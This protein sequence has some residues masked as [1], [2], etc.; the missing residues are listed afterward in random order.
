M[1][2]PNRLILAILAPFFGLSTLALSQEIGQ[3]EESISVSLIATKEIAIEADLLLTSLN[4]T[5]E[6]I[7]VLERRE[8]S[9]IARESGLT[10]A[11]L[12]SLQ[13]AQLLLILERIHPDATSL[14][15]TRAVDRDNGRILWSDF[16]PSDGDLEKWVEHIGNKI[17]ATFLPKNRSDR[18]RVS[19]R[20]LISETPTGSSKFDLQEMTLTALTIEALS[21]WEK[22]DVIER[23]DLGQVEFERFLTKTDFGLEKQADFTISGSFE[24]SGE[25]ATARLRISDNQQARSK[26][27]HIS[28][29]HGGLAE[30]AKQIG[31]AIAAETL[32]DDAEAKLV[33]RR[34]VERFGPWEANQF[35]DE[36][37]R[38][39]RLGL[40][41]LAARQAAAVN[42]IDFS[43]D[44]R[45]DALQFYAE[46]FRLFPSMPGMNPEHAL[47]H[48][49]EIH[50]GGGIHTPLD[51]WNHYR[52]GRGFDLFPSQEQWNGFNEVLQNLTTTIRRKGGHKDQQKWSR[53]KHYF[54]RLLTTMGPFFEQLL[55]S[56]YKRLETSSNFEEKAQFMRLLESMRDLDATRIEFFPSNNSTWRN[57]F[58]PLM[59][60]PSSSEAVDYLRKRLYPQERPTNHAHP[61]QEFRGFDSFPLELRN[62][63]MKYFEGSASLPGTEF[64]GRPIIGAFSNSPLTPQAAFHEATRP[65]DESFSPLSAVDRAIAEIE[66]QASDEARAKAFVEAQKVLQENSDQL[67]KLGLLGSYAAV[68][69]GIDNRR[70]LKGGF[71][72]A[73]G[74]TF[75]FWSSLHRKVYEHSTRGEWRLTGLLETQL[76]E[77]PIRNDNPVQFREF[78]SSIIEDIK[79]FNER[80]GPESKMEDWVL[81]EFRGLVQKDDVATIEGLTGIGPEEHL[82]IPFSIYS[83]WGAPTLASQARPF[84]AFILKHDIR[85]KK[86]K[87]DAVI[88]IYTF[89]DKPFWELIEIPASVSDLYYQHGEQGALDV[90]DDKLIVAAPGA[91]ATFERKSKT[92]EVSQHEFLRNK[93][94]F[95]FV[96]KHLICYLGPDFPIFS[97][98]PVQGLYGLNL[99][100]GEK[101]TFIDT[102]RR[103]AVYAA[104]SAKSLYF[105]PPILS[106]GENAFLLRVH[107]APSFSGGP[108]K[109][110]GLH[111]SRPLEPRIPSE[112]HVPLSS[113]HF[114]SGV[115][116]NERST[117]LIYDRLRDIRR[118]PSPGDEYQIAAFTKT[119]DHRDV[120]WLLDSNFGKEVELGTS[121]TTAA[122]KRPEPLFQ[123]PAE[124]T[125]TGT[126]RKLKPSIWYDG[127]LLL[128]LSPQ[129]TDDGR[130]L[131]YVWRNREQKIPIRVAIAF[132][133]YREKPEKNVTAEDAQRYNETARDTIEE[134][135]IEGNCLFFKFAYGYF[136]FSLEEFH[137]H[138]DSR[139][140]P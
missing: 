94:G 96:G 99:E 116:V 101:T 36:A 97:D 55:W 30:L 70:H 78:V 73:D 51:L 42:L 19:I 65:I 46:L 134:I 75:D 133:S 91:V 125:K 31:S 86:L 62:S 66:F 74:N 120:Q 60:M 115:S 16:Q 58:T 6:S 68:L 49:T 45:Y 140:V 95:S 35:N 84:E 33:P 18:I 27:K 100:T 114:T 43:D 118:D 64:V 15:A 135:S 110:F 24:L 76:T 59:L 39:F 98:S 34:L 93:K 127:E 54:S 28:T 12:D 132:D 22:V 52:R 21:S 87:A 92:W 20:S 124:F 69:L 137:K 63:I 131:L 80:V 2:P 50:I 105:K 40:Y 103:P 130:R 81:E 53:D 41:S 83:Y 57:P 9:E 44:S 61:P 8:L 102:T 128:L 4:N 104:D 48:S 119:P 109:I 139:A 85:D 129:L 79:N 23:L 123:F 17:S 136:M 7:S 126:S 38:N 13:S 26:T 122:V 1:A 14:I 106:H 138:L 111:S 113:Q 82:R 3:S 108:F 112:I 37:E 56:S 32:A 29:E 47:H 88:A 121:K 67:A 72:D 71:F 25:T 77:S 11:S 107:A 89:K 10:G 5:S 90:Q 117:V